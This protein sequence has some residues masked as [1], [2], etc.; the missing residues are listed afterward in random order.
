MKTKIKNAVKRSVSG[1]LAALISLSTF[2]T[3][4]SAATSGLNIGY[5]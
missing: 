3:N 2:T 5:I 4:A 1:T